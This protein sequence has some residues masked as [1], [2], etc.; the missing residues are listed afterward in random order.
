MFC[1]QC[2][3]TAGCTGCTGKAGVCGKKSDTANLQDKLTGALIGLARACDG[4]TNPTADTHRLL[5][6]GL[7]TTITNVS[8][9]NEA[10]QKQID[11]TRKVKLG[12]V[13]QCGSSEASCER[14]DDYDMNK[15]WEDDEDIRS[16]KSLILFGLRGMAAY[17]YHALM[18]GYTDD[19][20]SGFFAEGLLAVGKELT[21]EQLLPTVLKV[22]EVNLKCMALLDKANTETYGTPTPTT[23]TMKVEKGPFIVVTGHDLKDLQLLLEQTEG[24]GVNV[25]THGEMLP[26]H[27][28][29]D[30]KKYSHLKGNFGTAWQNQQKEF[31]GIPAAILYTTN[32]LMPPRASY[33]DRVFTTEV[34]A[35]PGAT[36]IGED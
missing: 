13:P 28:Y 3:Q 10:I 26:A 11:K 4:N 14:N 17:A 19:V 1:Y 33:A 29:P 15:L 30:L 24:K 21:V 27:A 23:V 12:L 34:V 25:Y 9:D 6:E 2:E 8:F 20:V 7:F 5:I 32:C 18:L 31:D 16:L 36:H 22:G 35:F